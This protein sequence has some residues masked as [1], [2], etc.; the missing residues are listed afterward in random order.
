MLKQCEFPKQLSAEKVL[1][2]RQNSVS[3]ARGIEVGGT[4]KIP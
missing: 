4:L 2:V 1:L 3:E